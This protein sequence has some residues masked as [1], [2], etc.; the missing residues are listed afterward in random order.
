MKTMNNFKRVLAVVLTLAMLV[1][2][3]VV[4]VSAATIGGWTTFAGKYLGGYYG[5]NKD[6]GFKFTETA[7][8]GIYV[9]IAKATQYGTTIA[10][11][12]AALPVTAVTSAEKVQL[13]GTT[14]SIELADTFTFGSIN[15]ASISMLWTDK[16]VYTMDEAATMVTG[17]DGTSSPAYLIG[18]QTTT[19]TNGLRGMVPPDA[20][21]IM[22]TVANSYGAYDAD[23]QMASDVKIYYFD[24]KFQDAVDH[25]P[26]YRWTF[27]G[28][29][30][31]TTP[32]WDSS[33]IVQAAQRIDAGNGIT[34]NVRADE[35]LGYIISINGN[36]YC[37]GK[38]VAYFPSNTGAIT[39][40][41][42]KT[43]SGNYI[44]SMTEAK[45]DIDLS[46]LT[47]ILD[48]GYLTIGSAGQNNNNDLNEY[49]ITYVNGMP[50]AQW[51]GEVNTHTECTY[52][53]EPIE[54]NW[55]AC[56]DPTY[57][58]Y[59]CTVC[60]NVKITSEPAEGHKYA[61][62]SET[63]AD[64]VTDGVLTTQCTVCDDVNEK[65]TRKLGHD[66]TTYE[67][68]LEPTDAATGLRTRS[69]PTCGTVEEQVLPMLGSDYT[70]YWTVYG[71]NEFDQT[72][73]W[74]EGADVLYPSVKEDGSLFLEDYAHYYDNCN[75]AYNVTA[76]MSKFAASINGFSAT[77]TPVNMSNGKIVAENEILDP[78]TGDV[79]GTEEI[80]VIDG[81]VMF[82]E[83]ISFIFTNEPEDYD[84]VGEYGVFSGE[85]STKVYNMRYGFVYDHEYKGDEHTVVITLMDYMNVGDGNTYGVA[86]DNIYDIIVYNIISGG[87][88]WCSKYASNVNIPMGEKLDVSFVN[89]Y[90]NGALVMSANINGFTLNMPESQNSQLTTD[91]YYFGV[92]AFSNGVFLRGTSFE[93]NTI[94]DEPAASFDGYQAPPHVCEF[95]T[96]V[97]KK[98][99]CTTDG[100]LTTKCAC[101]QG[102]TTEAIPALN[103]E[104]GCTYDAGNVTKQ[105]TCS[106]TGTIVYT[107][108]V[109]ATKK[110]ETLPKTEHTWGAWVTTVEPTTEAVGEETRTCEVC[111]ATETNELPMIEEV[112]TTPYIVGFD[113]YTV[114]MKNISDIKEIRFG[115]GHFTTGT[116]LKNAEKNVTLSAS[117]ANKY[118]VD[119]TFVYDLPWVGEYTF[120]V[121]CNDGSQYWLY[122]NLTEINPYVTSYGV[123]LTVN[124]FGENYKDAWLAKGTFNSYSEIKASTA[125]KYQA[126]ATKL[127]N[128]AKTTHDF[129]YTM[130]DPGDYTVLIRYNDGT[131]D[132]IHHE[133]TVTTPVLV[134]NGLQAIITNIPDIKIIRTAYGHHTSVESIKKAATVRYFNNKT[135]IK[136]AE[137]YMIQYRDEGEVTIIVEYNDGYKH[138]FYYNVAK[139]V[140]TVVQDGDTVTFGNLDDLYIIR[141]AA[142]KYTT[143]NNIKNAPNAQYKKLVNANENGEIVISGLTT[144]RWS[145]MVQ[146]NDDSYNFYVLDIVA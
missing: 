32:N 8:G 100:I 45:A 88:F 49:T 31:E 97:T 102:T 15:S 79:I 137:Q 106:A 7:D 17:E 22:V 41:M 103:P 52:G 16:P 131:V 44:G 115:I 59:K 143:A 25:V 90:N 23:G 84:E 105:P 67:V 54:T 13:D 21:G 34:F 82:P 112:I 83:T 55:T 87:N 81:T 12:A 119:G 77:I 104:V 2:M 128:Y 39:D 27:C 86:G 14:V 58:T 146:Y 73:E 62:V 129:T 64:C 6:R 109:C 43:Q 89:D 72:T 116:Q 94:C 110:T 145:F 33:G 66:W 144:G 139:K 36:D 42:Y 76:A 30:H 136:D 10:Q 113:N 9:D 65:I 37:L 91:E 93:I 114:T 53:D 47:E 48:G 134:E 127:G 35:T 40:E 107:C 123:K 1:P 60:G 130:T 125:F 118:I 141:Y 51:N 28:R 92:G 3:F 132:V 120:W 75:V 46:G 24:G 5:A 108:T 95:Y 71:Y 74:I 26:G 124:D 117:V 61:F 29:N 56:T 121:R 18:H 101:G 38:D 20:K 4:S 138:Y 142:G 63:F 140:P 96:E 99:T 69:C 98:A 57:Y 78:E 50:A 126:S 133:L 135:A 111:G 85:N 122:D 11:R 19:A 68:T 80:T 70:E